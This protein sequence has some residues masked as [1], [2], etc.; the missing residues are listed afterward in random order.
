[1]KGFDLD[2]VLCPEFRWMDGET[3]ESI[4]SCTLTLCAI[5]QPTAPYCIVTG[6]T[7]KDITHRWIEA[8]L[9]VQP[10]HIY[11]NETNMDPATFKASILN[12]ND[13]I[14]VFVESSIVQV[15]YLRAHTQCDIYHIDDLLKGL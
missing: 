9:L 7:N 1:M 14:D 5:F 4:L 6:R 11:V 15:E 12:R 2:G 13:S 10:L 8:N 3:P